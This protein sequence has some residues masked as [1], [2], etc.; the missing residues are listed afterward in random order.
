MGDPGSVKATTTESS[1]QRPS[2]ALG[3][4]NAGKLS[5]GFVVSLLE[6][7]NAKVFDKIILKAHG[8]YL[9]DGRN[10]VV[11]EFLNGTECDYLL[12]IDSDITWKP[13]HVAS[14]L[15]SASPSR[16][17]GGV[18]LNP[19]PQGICP[20]VYNS[21]YDEELGL[22]ILKPTTYDEINSSDSR[23]VPCGAVGTGFMC[24][25]RDILNTIGAKFEMPCEYFAEPVVN[26]VHVGE[27]LA[28]CLRAWSCG[29]NVYVDK[30][31]VVNHTKEITL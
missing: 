10:H 7:M 4:I 12:F 5:V 2:V 18:Y 6:C 24:I 22:S 8:P 13:H 28:F 23:L 29:F 19:Y 3:N 17:V 21:V 11:R 1:Q 20:V 9:D 14:I 31:T 27:D 26:G 16:V 30:G 15:E 25:H